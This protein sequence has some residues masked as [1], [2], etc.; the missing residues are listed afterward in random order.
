MCV[1]ITPGVYVTKSRPESEWVSYKRDNGI[2][3]IEGEICRLNHSKYL[4]K[5]LPLGRWTTED[6]W[7][8]TATLRDDSLTSS[9]ITGIVDETLTMDQLN[10]FMV[11]DTVYLRE[12]AEILTEVTW[13]CHLNSTGTCTEPLLE[14]LGVSA[15]KWGIYAEEYAARYN[16]S[17]DTTGGPEI[18]GY[19][20]HIRQVSM[21]QDPVYT[22][23]ALI[24]CA[25]LWP[26]LG[27]KI[28]SGVVDFGIFTEWVEYNLYPYSTGYLKYQAIVDDGIRR[29][30]VEFGTAD[31]IYRE[32]LGHEATFFNSV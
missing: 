8:S 20:D 31:K 12:V 5:I 30:V 4:N 11:D 18:S 19:I 26:W 14:F 10:S 22:V 1:G 24:P 23:V 28:G 7:R 25:R 13:Q 2:R 32:S 29:G 21:S 6:H 27:Q 16:V 15:A 17:T 9:F 3:S